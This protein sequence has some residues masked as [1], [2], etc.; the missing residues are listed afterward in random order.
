MNYDK[1][2]Q[3]AIDAMDLSKQHFE[4]TTRTGAAVL[5]STN[6]IYQ[7]AYLAAKIGALCRHAEETA[8]IHAQLHKDSNIIA[9]A[10]VFEKDK[11][12]DNYCSPCGLCRE[13]IHEI[14]DEFNNDI[15]V[16]MANPNGKYI[17]KKIS[18][19]LPDFWIK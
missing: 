13:L 2:V 9:I 17:V 14:S 7:G 12:T 15:D 8:I 10:V 11:G 1:L 18:E 3:S 5:T 16:V 19:L 6:K 4:G